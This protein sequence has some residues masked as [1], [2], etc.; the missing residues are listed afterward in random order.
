MIHHSLRKAAGASESS[1]RHQIRRGFDSLGSRVLSSQDAVKGLTVGLEQEFFLIGRE[2]L[3]ALHEESQ[4]FLRQ[5]GATTGWSVRSTQGS[6]LGEMITRV[7]QEHSGQR[8][9]AVKYDHHPHLM[10]VAFAYEGNLEAM[11]L[12]ISRTF[13]VM[14]E[15]ALKLGL[16]VEM[17]PVLAISPLH[18]RVVSPL[19]EFRALR[20]YRRL[21]LL[22][23]G[24]TGEES[25]LNYAS[26]IAATQTHI[27][28]TFWW[29]RPGL[30]EQLYRF[31]PALLQLTASATESGEGLLRS[32]WS[33][34]CEV[35]EGYPLVGYPDLPSWSFESWTDG[36]M[37]SPL[38]GGESL[39]WSGLSVREM[40]GFPLGEA[41][42]FFEQ[43]RDLQIIRP[44]WFGT[45]EFRA[46]PVQRDSK[47]VLR[48]LALRLGLTS[49]S[50]LNDA[51]SERSVSD[52]SRARSE[53]W[54][55]VRNRKVE[56]FK[57]GAVQEV[58]H[59][60]R[61]GLIAREMNEERFLV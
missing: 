9:T 29:L 5:L 49:Y 14:D 25:S 6:I 42:R 3:P 33:A 21:L 36:L 39:E 11:A 16:R 43:V 12:T 51:T 31:E 53:W 60:A 40:G 48:L 44:K 52:W 23:K 56:H 17:E 58:L 61:F 38:V 19:S 27:G 28:G 50:L 13:E 32:R 45:L 59:S 34:F 47:S 24:L 54:D 35:F 15:V 7:S 8:Y 10:E 4:A 30:V 37:R 41:N 2:G 55:R 22:K 46:D 18:E 26:V 1:L 20:N 57:A